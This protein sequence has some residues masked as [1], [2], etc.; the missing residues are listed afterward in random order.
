MREATFAILTALADGPRHGYG[1]MSEVSA[2]SNGHVQLLAGTLYTALERLRS[3]G[4]IE[5][6][7]EEVVQGRLRR[8]YGLTG[9]GE[10]ALKSEAERRRSAAEQALIRLRGRKASPATQP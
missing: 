6:S 7:R 5:V 1:I 10:K 8:F 2:L 3:E 9:S 4:V